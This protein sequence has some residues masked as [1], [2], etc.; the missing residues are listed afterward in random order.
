[1]LLFLLVPFSVAALEQAGDSSSTVASPLGSELLAAAEAGQV[2]RIQDLLGKGAAIESRDQHGRT[3]LMV[4][5]IAGQA[6]AVQLL[7]D[8]G[9]D[10]FARNIHGADAFEFAVLNSRDEVVAILL[11]RGIDLKG[12]GGQALRMSA[13]AGGTRTAKVLLE[14]GVHVD[15]R[16]SSYATPLMHAVT[17]RQREMVAFLIERGA[18]VNAVDRSGS[19]PLSLSLVGPWGRDTKIAKMLKK[20]GARE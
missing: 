2:D 13:R 12:R 5:T 20:A 15:A 4:A 17:S 9:S 8:E 16:D 6:R 19:T 7:L 1:M 14:H 3:P 18:D 10:L 11:E